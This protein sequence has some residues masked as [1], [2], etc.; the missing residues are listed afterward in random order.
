[1]ARSHC[2]GLGVGWRWGTMDFY[3]L[4]RTV[5]TVLR[6]G[7]GPRSIV[8]YCPL[9]AP[10][11]YTVPVQC[12]CV[13]MF[14]NNYNWSAVRTDCLAVR[15]VWKYLLKESTGWSAI[16]LR[17]FC[18]ATIRV[19]TNSGLNLSNLLRLCFSGNGCKRNHQEIISWPI[20]LF[21]RWLLYCYKFN[22]TGQY[23]Q[24]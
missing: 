16:L 3:I 23:C 7:M 2:V 13:I 21:Y 10:G 5:H 19:F 18:R 22:L 6:P 9:P 17:N 24:A 8:F 14:E 11:P 1:M 4:C 12:E 15:N 20:I